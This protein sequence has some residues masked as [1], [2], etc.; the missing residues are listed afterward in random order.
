MELRI[1]LN[2]PEPSLRQQVEEVIADLPIRLL[3]ISQSF[4]GMDSPLADVLNQRLEELQPL[5]VFEQRCLNKYQNP[6][7]EDM[8]ALFNELLAEVQA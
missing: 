2:Q 3:K 6:P 7:P 8:I 1:L 4:V 5:A